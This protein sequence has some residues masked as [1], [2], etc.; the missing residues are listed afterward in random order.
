MFILHYEYGGQT[1]FE[2][3][4]LHKIF[5]FV[6]EPPINNMTILVTFTAID[7]MNYTHIKK[8]DYCLLLKLTNLD[9][10][11]QNQTKVNVCRKITCIY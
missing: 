7:N 8:K 10:T 6:P 2:I 3:G 1:Y 4:F 11:I 5:H 9:E